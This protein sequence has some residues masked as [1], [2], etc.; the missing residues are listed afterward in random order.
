MFCRKVP[1]EVVREILG[2]VDRRHVLELEITRA[3]D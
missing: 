2:R 1:V 3:C